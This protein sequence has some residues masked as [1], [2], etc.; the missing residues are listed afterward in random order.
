[1]VVLQRLPTLDMLIHFGLINIDANVCV[2]CDSRTET[3][4][5]LFCTCGFAKD[6][7]V[8]RV[9]GVMY[10]IISIDHWITYVTNSS[11]NDS[12]IYKIKAASYGC[13]LPIFGILGIK[14]ASKIKIQFGS[15]L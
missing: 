7:I 3:P 14:S 2:L 6:L 9:V 8:M 12:F 1:M 5:H 15:S 4:D 10:T 13:I 11:M